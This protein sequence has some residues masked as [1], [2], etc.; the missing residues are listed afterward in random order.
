MNLA[1][2]ISPA[3][4]LRRYAWSAKLPLSVLTDFEELALYDCRLKPKKEDGAKT[5]R[6]DCL[7]YEQYPNRWDEIASIFSKEAILSDSLENHAE[8][9]K[10]RRGT[11][12][13]EPTTISARG[14][15]FSAGPRVVG[16]AIVITPTTT[17]R[18]G[19]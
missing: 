10:R 19:P 7:T 15:K 1:D 9:A 4:Q 13:V 11:T 16:S 8:E 6:V 2:D 17:N 12:L 5:A 18:R 14:T 3:F